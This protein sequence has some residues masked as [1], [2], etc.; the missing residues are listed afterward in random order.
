MMIYRNYLN[1]NIDFVMLF[2]IYFIRLKGDY[3][4][5][6]VFEIEDVDI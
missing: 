5:I 4:D 3:F 6:D 2:L 1:I